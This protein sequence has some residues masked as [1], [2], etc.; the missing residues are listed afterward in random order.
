MIVLVSGATGNTG[1]EVMRQLEQAGVTVRAMTRSPKA[2][3]RLRGEG[4]EAI[5]ADLHDPGSLSAAVA[6]VDAVYVANPASPHLAVHEGN[7]AQASQAA[8]VGL[9]VKLSVIGCSADSPITFGRL[10]FAA[11]QAIKAS[12]VRWTMVRPNGFMQNTLAW[13]DQIASGTVYGPVMDARWSI[14]DVRDI[15]ALAVEA[16]RDPDAHAGE[17]YSATGPEASSPREQVA[18]LAEVLGRPIEAQEVST[19]Q[20]QES[21]LD[22]GWPGWSVLRMAELFGLYADGLAQGTS[23]DIEQVTGRRPRDFRQFA[24]DHRHGF[25]A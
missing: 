22:S 25:A 8:G 9:L 18:V 2:A 3:D 1:A 20:A 7:L 16:L 11:E 14:V 6:G 24:V 5:V 19:A 21:M 4:R 12:G 13:A 17:A 10:H 15:A 23:P